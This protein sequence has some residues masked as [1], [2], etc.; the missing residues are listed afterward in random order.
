MIRPLLL[1]SAFLAVIL[2]AAQGGGAQA[3]D[4]TLVL[5]PQEF[6][7]SNRE[8][9]QLL[10]VEEQLGDKLIGQVSEGL[11]FASSNPAVVDVQEGRAVPKGNGE[12]VI[13]VTAGNR[14]AQSKVKVESFDQPFTWSFR[15]HV[16]GILAKAG[17]SSGACHGA[18][19]G[20]NGFRLSLRG[21]DPEGDF[22]NITRQS[23]GRRIVPSDPGRSLLLTKPTGAV[24]HKGGI[25]FRV[26]SLEYR[27][28]SEW[29]ASG[30]APPK[31]EDPRVTKIEI[32]P[33]QL[34]LKKGAQQQFSVR[35]H[36]T[37]GHV[38]DVT[39]WTKYTSA[40]ESVATVNDQGTVQVVGYGE[41]ALTAWY[42]SKVVVATVSS[43]FENNISPE[44]FA[45][46]PRKNLIDDKVL[47]KLQALNIAPSPRCSD[48]E[49]IRRLYIDTLGV[50][51]TADEVRAFLADSTADKRDRLIDSVFQRSEFVDYWT[52]KWSDLLLVSSEKLAPP[53]MW[54]YFR[55]IR[56]QVEANTPWDQFVRKIVTAKGA[57]LENGGANFFVLHADPLDLS[58]TTTVAFLGMSVN[59]AR[60]HN[61]PLE[62][63]TNNQYYAMANLYSRV[64]LKTTGAAGNVEVFSTSTGD[65]IQP[66][67]GKPQPPAPLDATP[68]P[69]E[70]ARDRREY[71]ADWLTSSEN[72][73]FSRAIVN[74]VWANFFKVG[75]VEPVDDMRLTNPSSN[76]QLL[77]ALAGYLA[78]QK[79]DLRALMRLILQSETYQRSSETNPQNL[80]DHSFYSH[81]YPR[82]MMAEAMLDSISQVTGVPTQ[83]G[84]FPQEWRAMQLP[85][86]AVNSYFLK[87]FG[88]PDRVITCEC[89]RTAEPT[90]VQVL[91]FSN[92]DSLNQKLQAPGNKI[93]KLLAD[94]L[95]FDQ[96]LDEL[97]LSTLCRYPSPQKKTELTAEWDK[98]ADGDRRAF[99]E[100]L[101]WSILSTTEF[102]FNH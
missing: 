50:L 44:V 84:D 29:L 89:E 41:G 43:P 97:F 66:L 48:E 81:Y 96:I 42:A 16:E 9:T 19:A 94:K 52:Y 5:L 53:A 57:T 6:T 17:C 72:P 71:L 20:K 88:R 23:N 10:I 45:Q 64:R 7:L 68:L 54:S 93:D 4:A 61:H 100:D 77:G 39:R 47:D 67:S 22:R 91:H 62:K 90:M 98:T 28:I 63:W 11:V 101:L 70:S 8:T 27:V 55:W 83:F 2:S 36:F 95:P 21:Y 35:A 76:D 24:P 13:T 49:F 15:N 60:C 87:T 26:D 51:P 33:A 69:A 56:E 59:C 38:E 37:D 86:A 31:A 75:L 85:D 46:A 58:E 25:R 3:A 34:V 78:D 65:L 1:V 74:R 73:Y 40:N 99:L 92:G 82:R 32:V 12:A 80:E 30:A 79:F 14:T 18:Q 102:M